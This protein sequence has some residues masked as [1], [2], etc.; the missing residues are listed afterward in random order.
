MKYLFLFI[1]IIYNSIKMS[2]TLINNN[3]ENKQAYV[4][5]KFNFGYL[6][7]SKNKKPTISTDILRFSESVE[8]IDSS[9][10]KNKRIM[11]ILEGSDETRLTNESNLHDK[12]SSYNNSNIKV[13]EIDSDN[14]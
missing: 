4:P 9:V 7:P 5:N 12:V 10:V 11:Y 14:K 3:V 2:V 8:A 6:D 1:K 13:I